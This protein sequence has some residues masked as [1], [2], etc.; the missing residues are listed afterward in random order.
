MFFLRFENHYFSLV[1]ELRPEIK[2]RRW[3]LEGFVPRL[4]QLARAPDCRLETHGCRQPSGGPRFKSGSADQK[5]IIPTYIFCSLDIFRYV[6][7]HAISCSETILSQYVRI[8]DTCQE[9]GYLVFL[10]LNVVSQCSDM[11]CSLHVL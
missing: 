11:F 1:L 10:A 4:A 8:V 9:L 7:A 6:L 5:I 3:W 2:I